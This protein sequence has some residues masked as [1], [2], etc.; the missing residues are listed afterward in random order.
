MRQIW[1]G[2]LHGP[3]SL[4][5]LVQMLCVTNLP[6]CLFDH[7]PPGVFD[8]QGSGHDFYGVSPFVVM[9][10][11]ALCCHET[12]FQHDNRRCGTR[13]PALSPAWTETA[14]VTLT[15]TTARP[16][17]ITMGVVQGCSKGRWRLNWGS[18]SL[19]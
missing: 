8:G 6:P 7:T 14:L 17:C 19:P 11:Q 18:L 5:V 4:I 9:A 3:P 1:F 16:K 10:E 12:D 2:D 13:L 15:A